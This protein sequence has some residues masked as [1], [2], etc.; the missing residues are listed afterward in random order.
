M[1]Y[2]Q[3]G[4][5]ILGSSALICSIGPTHLKQVL[6]TRNQAFQTISSTDSTLTIVAACS[7][8]LAKFPLARATIHSLSTKNIFLS[9]RISQS[10][11]GSTPSSLDGTIRIRKWMERNQTTFSRNSLRRRPTLRSLDRSIRESTRSEE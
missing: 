11:S 6:L 2:G 9:E 8:I 7:A 4:D 5:P 1:I 3:S 10:S